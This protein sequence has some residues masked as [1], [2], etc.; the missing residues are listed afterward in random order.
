MSIKII[1]Q[2]LAAFVLIFFV[3]HNLAFCEKDDNAGGVQSQSEF[4]RGLADRGLFES[5]EFFY[6]TESKKPNLDRQNKYSLTTALVYSRT[7][8]LLTAPESARNKL[9]L[10]L[11]II[12]TEFQNNLNKLQSAQQPINSFSAEISEL[13]NLQLQIAAAKYLFGNR[14][15]LEAETEPN[16]KSINL[17]N[18]AQKNFL[19]AIE[20]LKKLNLF[21]AAQQ[22]P[23]F[24]EQINFLS[25]KVDL[26]LYLSEFSYA[27]LES[28]DNNRYDK[29]NRLAVSFDR[30]SEEKLKIY[31][32]KLKL[33]DS[34]VSYWLRE[35][36]YLA[37]CAR[38]ELAASY[39]LTN[40]FDKAFATLDGGELDFNDAELPE[41]LRLK[42]AA[43]R[44]RFLTAVEFFVTINHNAKSKTANIA[45]NK[46][47]DDKIFDDKISN[48]PQW[49]INKLLNLPAPVAADSF[50]YCLARL[51][52]GLFLANCAKVADSS[53]ELM[54]IGDILKLVRQMEFYVPSS[55]NCAAITIASNKFAQRKINNSKLTAIKTA[56][57]GELAQ[58]K[59][60]RNQIDEAVKLYELAGRV[61]ELAGESETAVKNTQYAISLLYKTLKQLETAKQKNAQ[62]Q[63]NKNEIEDEIFSC[64]FRIVALL[65]GAGRRFAGDGAAG[66]L[67]RR[68]IDEATILYKTKRLT[69]DDYIALLNGYLENWGGAND[70]GAY[71]LRAAN[72]L[73]LNGRFEEALE[74]L[75]KIPNNCE[76]A[77]EA[78]ITA[79]LCFKKIHNKKEKKTNTDNANT[80][81]AKTNGDDENIQDIQDGINVTKNEFN[82]FKRRLRSEVLSWSEADA[83]TAIKMA[84]RL[85]YKN[86]VPVFY[87]ELVDGFLLRDMESILVMALERCKA[88]QAVSVIRLKMM[89]IIAYNLRGNH[90]KS[91]EIIKQINDEQVGL[92]TAGERLFYRRLGVEVLAISG[93][94]DGAAKVLEK[95]LLADRRNLMLLELKAEIFARQ[96]DNNSLNEAVKTYSLIASIA[97]EKSEQW[98][99]AREKIIQILIK[100]GNH[101]EAKKIYAKLK[102][103][104]PNLGN[105][106]RKYKLEKL[107]ENIN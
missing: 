50:D 101:A 14:I 97:K 86:G 89:L 95:I 37:I 12:E 88:A 102:F 20:Q 59:I 31:S 7:L 8:Q 71:R 67:Y 66:D 99:N 65:C 72:L 18:E 1:V 69:L 16:N 11:A 68:G 78:I 81:G 94:G 57:L 29:L 36:Y 24:T 58:Y 10:K 51:E 54:I 33:S 79:D 27:L 48:K 4:L 47:F 106:T 40:E 49:N 53:T 105:K 23:A 55:G 76:Q 43:E 13:V 74:F 98:W 5:V 35:N 28:A 9:K 92:L 90:V 63:Q 34:K 87:W 70:S 21:L 103:L 25:G 38:V 80:N 75:D 22:N 64:R 96:N 6:E 41:G 2:K 100:Q 45:D 15:K 52:R 77:Q 73:A 61:A 82:W 39:R 84:E 107:I 26:Y 83:A 91:A 46:I 3:T 44:I 42:I 104:H 30:L 85:F 32:S 17:I 19:T 56:V 93:D 60:G 62:N